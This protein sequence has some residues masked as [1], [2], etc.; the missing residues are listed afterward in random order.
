[1]FWAQ[2][3]I[4]IGSTLGVYFSLPPADKQSPKDE[5]RSVWEKL[6]RI[7]YLG[8]A[9]LVSLPHLHDPSTLR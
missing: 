8:S 2:T 5:S 4:A 6:R 7:D 9:F 3:P 1:M